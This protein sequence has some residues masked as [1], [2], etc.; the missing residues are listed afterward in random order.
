[1]LRGSVAAAQDVGLPPAELAR[2]QLELAESLIGTHDVG[3]AVAVAEEEIAA[4]A[5]QLEW[6]SCWPEPPSSCR[7]P[8]TR[9]CCAACAD[10]ASARSPPCRPTRWGY[11]P[12]LT[13]QLAVCLVEH[14]EV[15]EAAELAAAALAA[16]RESGDPEVQLEALAARHLTITVP[17]RVE[18]RLALGREAVI[19]GAAARRPVAAL[20]GHLWRLDAG[21]QLGNL[22]S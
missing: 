21:V 13:A 18:E 1:M 9:R 20:W 12:R 19:L 10:C 16:A 22:P 5:E 3:S 17:Q 11:E 4:A 2:L 6:P 15:E 8:A 7:A 14:D